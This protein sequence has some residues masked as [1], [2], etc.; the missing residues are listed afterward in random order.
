MGKI[1]VDNKGRCLVYSIQLQKVSELARRGETKR[2]GGDFVGAISDFD[3]ALQLDPH[4]VSALR[5]RGDAKRMLDDFTGAIADLD[6]ALK[7][8]PRNAFA[9]RS[10]GD[11]KRMLDDHMGAIHDLDLALQL[12]PRNPVALSSRGDAKR[13]LDDGMGAIADLDI[14][15]QMDPKNSFALSSR[16]ASKRLM[17]DFMGAIA[18]LDRALEMEPTDAFALRRRGEAKRLARDFVGAIQD[19]DL[20]LVI[21]PA[22]SLALWRRGEAKRQQGDA[23]GALGDLNLA[24]QLEPI[25]ATALCSRSDTKLMLQDYSGAMED[26]DAAVQLEPDNATALRSRGELKRLSGDFQGSIHDL[27]R[28]LQ[29]EPQNA[30]ALSSRG[31]AKRMLDDC[32]GALADLDLALELEPNNALDLARRGEVKREQGDFAGAIDDLDLALELEPRNVVALSSR[33]DAKRM[34]ND[35]VGALEDLDLALQ[36]EPDNPFALCC[37]GEAKKM[38]ESRWFVQKADSLGPLNCLMSQQLKWAIIGAGPVGLTLALTLAESMQSRGLDA[39]VAKVE[40]FLSWIERAENSKWQRKPGTLSVEMVTLQDPVLDSLSPE[41]RGAF[42]AA[43]S[44]PRPSGRSAPVAGIEMKLLAKAQQPPFNTY[45]RIHDYAE[46]DA[47]P[48]WLSSL[49]CDVIVTDSAVTRRSFPGAFVN[50]AAPHVDVEAQQL[51]LS[52][53]E[54]NESNLVEADFA[55]GINLSFGASKQARFNAIFSMA[56]NIYQLSSDEASE[57]GCL[58]IRITKEEYYELLDA[59]GRT[60]ESDGGTLIRLFGEE[61]LHLIIDEK[62]SML[63]LRLPWLRRRI[64]EGFKLYGLQ[65]EQMTSITGVQLRPAYAQCFYHVLDGAAENTPKLLLLTGEAAISDHF[66]PCRGLNSGLKSAA[67][68]VKMWLQCETLAEGAG[69]YNSFMDKLRRFEMQQRSAPRQQLPWG[70]ALLRSMESP[71]AQSLDAMAREQEEVNRQSFLENCKLWR[72]FLQQSEGW[73]HESVTDEDLEQQLYKTIGP[74]ELEL[75]LMVCSASTRPSSAVSSTSSRRSGSV[76][77]IERPWLT[78]PKCHWLEPVDPSSD[79]HWLR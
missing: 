72:D 74:K 33:G 13:M 77:G 18:D 20:A 47:Q 75:H 23:M 26:L 28:S 14:A 36:I 4:D 58:N 65:L 17:G 69:K 12:E 32:Q 43:G 34:L 54:G 55:L 7:L 1:D 30:V 24:L 41:L 63:Q 76:A 44:S 16:A 51:P 27:D 19:L 64:A 78:N 57:S 21:E 37:R 29:L 68:I 49:C 22:N 73:P 50:P 15:L 3:L 40:I 79:E 9:L 59:T 60:P 5:S 35:C 38:E 42:E 46:T 62:P 8:E 39:E 52:D 31:D 45:I 6:A 67:A 11:A 48:E 70:G 53:A 2:Q 56:Q 61:D 66:W 71:E 10:R 25:N